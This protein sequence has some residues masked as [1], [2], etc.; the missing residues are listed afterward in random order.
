MTFVSLLCSVVLKLRR[1][2]CL[3]NTAPEP[4]LSQL[5]FNLMQVHMTEFCGGKS[6]PGSDT[7]TLNTWRGRD[8]YKHFPCQIIF[9]FAV[10]SCYWLCRG[11]VLH[12]G[13]LRAG[14][15]RYRCRISTR[16]SR[17]VCDT[18]MKW[19][20][21][22]RSFTMLHRFIKHLLQKHDRKW[23]HVIKTQNRTDR[24]LLLFGPTHRKWK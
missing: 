18:L 16:Q 11:R 23:F 13:P 14:R 1:L 24:R 7:N 22:E 10:T 9:I 6:W 19:C 8:H 20:Q 3:T 4:T 15:E 5:G 2:H 17:R 21:R 12:T